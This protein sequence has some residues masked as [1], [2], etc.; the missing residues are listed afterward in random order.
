M[1]LKERR[2]ALSAVL[3]AYVAAQHP[4]ATIP[5][6][7][8]VLEMENFRALI[9]D[10]PLQEGTIADKFEDAMT[11][12]PSL[13]DNWRQAKNREL[14]GIMKVER[15]GAV[16]SMLLLATTFFQCIACKFP[17][18]YSQVLGHSCL[19][20]PGRGNSIHIE[21]GCTPWNHRRNGVFFHRGAFRAAESILRACHVNP[22]TVTTEGLQLADP[23]IEC[24]TCASLGQ[25][26]V[27]MRWPQAVRPFFLSFSLPVTDVMLGFQR[28]IMYAPTLE[29]RMC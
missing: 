6:I 8:D 2:A 18:E 9:E 17:V 28:Y 1:V 7:A 25:D 10:T 24:L 23:L 21:L 20:Y 29:L 27:M 15:T 13:V 5:N 19:T 26:R 16:E 4:H 14:V 11:E 3:A 22:E 12:F